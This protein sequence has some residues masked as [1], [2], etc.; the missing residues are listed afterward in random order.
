MSWPENAY[1][2]EGVVDV[3]KSYPLIWKSQK[4][5]KQL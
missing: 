2:L 1:L 3:T 5:H 4:K